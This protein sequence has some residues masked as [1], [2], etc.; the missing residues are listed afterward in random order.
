[1]ATV[2]PNLVQGRWRHWAA[3][4]T[5]AFLVFI[6]VAVAGLAGTA[7]AEEALTPPT[8]PALPSAEGPAAEASGAEEAV[9]G[10]DGREAPTLAAPAQADRRAGVGGEDGAGTPHLP[11]TVPGGLVLDGRSNDLDRVA[12]EGQEAPEQRL[13]G[14]TE[15]P[16]NA[17][18]TDAAP[19]EPVATDRVLTG[20]A[21]TDPAATDRAATVGRPPADAATSALHPS[22]V[23]PVVDSPA[24]LAPAPL[25][26]VDA[27]TT[28][29]PLRMVS[30]GSGDLPD[31]TVRRQRSAPTVAA[32]D[33]RRPAVAIPGGGIVE[34][35]GEAEQAPVR[36][37]AISTSGPTGPSRPVSS[38]NQL[39]AGSMA[40]SAM[41]VVVLLP[42]AVLLVRRA[43]KG[44]GR[45]LGASAGSATVRG[46][47]VMGAVSGAG[48]PMTLADRRRFAY[49]APCPRLSP[50][51]PGPAP[52]D[53]DLPRSPA[54]AVR[55]KRCFP[56]VTAS[57]GPR[58]RC[59]GSCA[60]RAWLPALP[61]RVA[62]A[63]VEGSLLV[64]E[65][66]PSTGCLPGG[67]RG[68]PRIGEGRHRSPCGGRSTRSTASR[69]KPPPETTPN[70]GAVPLEQRWR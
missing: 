48:P 30:G 25:L 65:G 19:A 42:T 67:E 27:A 46:N 52:F 55:P 26:V 37:P 9:A 32:T 13:Q 45:R 70:C 57:P 62:A 18:S 56:L 3:S 1:M 64:A 53:A 15:T 68:P 8:M 50:P 54:V 4:G 17:L 14:D 66:Q 61:R 23:G 41:A 38:A 49:P 43:G 51:S 59:A 47:K 69:R 20:R 33:G 5:V 12:D 11:V 40:A 6:L 16:T 29:S 24:L 44:R 34:G 10:R 31:I 21:P 60:G 63:P 39:E 22:T 58:P 7:A 35:V 36:P 28:V 2:A